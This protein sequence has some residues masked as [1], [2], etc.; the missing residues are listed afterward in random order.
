MLSNR[1]S[2]Y[3]FPDLILFPLVLL[4]LAD[5]AEN[6]ICDMTVAT[7]LKTGLL[8]RQNHTNYIPKCVTIDIK[9]PKIE[10]EDK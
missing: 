9:I 3:C 6:S 10:D 7:I 1:G 5:I 4:L 2:R 8:S